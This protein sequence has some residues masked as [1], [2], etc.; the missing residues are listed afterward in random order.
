MQK[1]AYVS[2]TSYRCEIN[3]DLSQ[4]LVQ[5]ANRYL[6]FDE[7]TK[8]HSYKEI[9]GSECSKMSHAI[10]VNSGEFLISTFRQASWL[11][12]TRI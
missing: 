12:L 3:H 1:L 2:H 9:R 11:T 10:I 6:V 7:A 8:Q 5:N 4:R